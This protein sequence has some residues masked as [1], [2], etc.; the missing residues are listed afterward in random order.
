MMN[1]T[2]L[3]LVTGSILFGGCV[4]LPSPTG[5]RTPAAATQA[6]SGAATSGPATLPGRVVLLSSS[7]SL[8]VEDPAESMAELER[9]IDEAGGYVTSASASSSSDGGYAN[10]SARVPVDSL[11]ELRLAARDGALQI[12][13]DSTYSQDVTTEYE[14]LVERKR[15]LAEAEDA[16]WSLVADTT[17]RQRVTSLQLLL[18]LLHQ[19]ALNIDGQL[20]YY[21]NDGGLATFDISFSSALPTAY[22]TWPTPT[23]TPTAAPIK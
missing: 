9:R 12:Q 4:T 15:Q 19:E 23:A 18:A 2:I 11:T 7:L 22:P 8:I 17:D 21:H 5:S 13:Y 3:S 10:L 20:D 1:K 16:V 6:P 14:T